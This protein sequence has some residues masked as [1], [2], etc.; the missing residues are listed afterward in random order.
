[1]NKEFVW[2]KHGV[3]YQIYPRSYQDTSGNGVGDL[4]GIL[5]RL[6]YL[7]WLGIDAIWI[8]PMYPS[9]M[10]DFGYD[11]ANY[12]DVDPMFGS[13]ADMDALIAAA[14]TRGMKVVLDFV[15]NHTSWDHP[16]FKDARSSKD[17]E[18][19][20]WY[21]WRDP[22]PDGGPPNNWI[23]HFGGKS[24]WEFD[25]ASGQYYFH[26][27]LK[28]QPDLNWRNPAV[29]DA[30]ADN[31]RFWFKRG[32][33]GFRVDV[34][35]GMM[36]DPEWRD[37]PVNPAWTEG[38]D[39][40]ER[41]DTCR[42]L[43]HPDVHDFNRWQRAVADEFADRMLVGETYVPIPD[44]PKYY[45][46]GD[47]EYHLAFNFHMIMAD[48]GA[49]TVRAIV[50]EYDG[51]LPEFG[52]PNYALGNHDRY[53]VATRAGA[54]QAR[55]AML[56]LLTLRG[57]PTLYYGD[58]LGMQNVEIPPEMEVDPWGLLAPGLGLGRDPVRTPMQWDAG[59]NAGF[60]SAETTWLPISKD[61]QKVNVASQKA[62]PD[63]MLNLTRTLLTL[64]RE[65][66]ALV[67]GSYQE[68]ATVDAVFGYERKIGN[69]RVWVFLN[70]S[71]EPQPIP[72]PTSPCSITLSTYMDR[73]TT[74]VD[75]RL[76]LR[77]NEGVIL[78]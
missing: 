49:A 25:E 59:V 57:T 3:I 38:M 4:K 70:F 51:V 17:S 71:A 76:I 69:E 62:Q 37:A 5:Q 27:F 73:A 18:K 75:N 35:H 56:L 15:P 6:D 7:A 16:W 77:P 1:M 74:M 26:L 78:R 61:Y 24:G 42:Y 64:R 39:P 43:N 44:L 31:L 22:A 52:W 32:V 41:L 8:S 33:D 46:T 30:M 63:S 45:G 9:P 72:L 58:E 54:A 53:R 13:L 67:Q 14:H 10:H 28:E 19:R 23:S 20:D 68:C 29:R 66:E 36:K 21:I 50:N 34:A 60:S 2:W 55:V 65:T 47:D 12:V 40:F 48:W 11:V